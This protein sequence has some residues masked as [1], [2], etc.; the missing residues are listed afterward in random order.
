MNKCKFFS[1][2]LFFIFVVVMGIMTNEIN[3][4]AGGLSFGVRGGYDTDSKQILIGGQSELGKFLEIA[5]FSP[6]VD[7]GFGQD[8]TTFAFNGD[9]HVFLT[10][11]GASATLYGGAGPTF[12]VFKPKGGNSDSEIGLTLSGGIKF[13]AA[14][15]RVYNLEGRFGFDKM[16]DLRILLG[17]YF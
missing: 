10:P 3:A 4:A 17:V 12:F 9:V 2:A 5:R 1:G 15:S 8:M 16:P 7:Y 13:G 6:S 14:K 11:P